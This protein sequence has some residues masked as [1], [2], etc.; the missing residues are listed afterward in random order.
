MLETELE[1]ELDPELELELEL[2]DEFDELDDELEL[3]GAG[4][5]P[6][7]DDEPALELEVLRSVDSDRFGGGGS[8]LFLSL[9]IDFTLDIEK[10][11]HFGVHSTTEVK[12]EKSVR[13]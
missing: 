10:C 4:D 6:A 12:R 1:P 11:S 7:L 5:F 8:V 9:V 2:D 13:T 3:D